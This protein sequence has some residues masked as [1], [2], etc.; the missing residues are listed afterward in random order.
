M[1]E[2]L[3]RHS[4][5]STIFQFTTKRLRDFIDSRHRSSAWTR[6]PTEMDP[7]SWTGKMLKLLRLH[8]TGEFESLMDSGVKWWS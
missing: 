8:S 2:P 5:D 1:L 7:E 3:D 4:G 6:C